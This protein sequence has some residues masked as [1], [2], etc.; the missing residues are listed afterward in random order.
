[1]RE[2]SLTEKEKEMYKLCFSTLVISTLLFVFLSFGTTGTITGAVVSEEVL[3]IPNGLIDYN[4]LSFENI[5]QEIALDA[6]LQAENDMKDLEEEG[7]GVVWFNDTLIEA[8]K[9]FEGQDY[10]L[11]LEDIESIEDQDR[12]EKALELLSEAQRTIGVEVDYTKVLELTKSIDERKKRALEIK[13]LIRAMELRIEEF[14][15]QGVDVSSAEE[16]LVSAVTEFDNERYEDSEQILGTIDK[17]LIDIS[18]E[19]TITKTIYRA[20]KENIFV[21]LKEHYKPILLLFGS[22]LIIAILLYNRVMM[23]VLRRRIRDMKVEKEILV[24]L[25]KKSQTDYFARGEI[26]KKTYEVKLSMFKKRFAELKQKLPISEALLE[27]RL[28]SKRVI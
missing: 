6:I 24:E 10:N 17:N 21:F 2:S 25:M 15:L 27:K 20:G 19:S 11:L 28:K 13:D 5:T 9:Y 14:K 23:S 7:F 26:T 12:R 16:I 22:L 1:M 4:K 18:A 8:K 3:T